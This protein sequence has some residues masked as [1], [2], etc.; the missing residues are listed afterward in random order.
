MNLRT[1]TE[2]SVEPI[3]LAEA[4][5]FARI[6]DA[7]TTQDAWLTM[8]IAAA[9]RQAENIT[10]RAFVER[11]YELSLPCWPADGII[12]LPK[13]PL[14]RV[15]AVR[16]IDRD[17]DEQTLTASLYQVDTVREPGRIKPSYGNVWPTVRTEDFNTIKIEFVAGYS[18][19]GSPSDYRAAL[20]ETLKTWIAA[21][22]S[23]MY[24]HRE[25]VVVGTSTSELPRNHLD[26]LLDHLIVSLF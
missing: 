16:Y 2:P 18:P 3:T 14:Q 10:R 12:V 21:R 7:D 17:G 24:E 5:T 26:G 25:T 22:L 19:V 11:T 1:V 23:T 9:R 20:P 15:N 13:P 4:R 6:D 8:F